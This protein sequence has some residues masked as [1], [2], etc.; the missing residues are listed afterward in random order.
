MPR[1]ATSPKRREDD[2]P[3]LLYAEFPL[4]M[5]R[6]LR[7]A[8]GTL[9]AVDAAD[10]PEGAEE[11]FDIVITSD[12]P[13]PF[14]GGLLRLVHT[15]EAVDM[16][17]AT[18]GLSFLLEH[19]GPNAPHRID[20]DLHVGVVENI[21]LARGQTRGQVRFGTSGRALQTRED[22]RGGIRLFISAGWLPLARP[23]LARAG[24]GG[25]PDLYDMPRWQLCESSSVSVPADPNARVGYSAWGFEIP[26]GDSGEK[27]A[28]GGIEMGKKVLGENGKVIDVADSD[29]RPALSEIQLRGLG[30]A[31]RGGGGG[32]GPSDAERAQ[33]A[34]EIM[35]LCVLHGLQAR[36]GEFIGQG[37]SLEQVKS[38]ILDIRSTNG[39]FSGAPAA[40]RLVPLTVKEAE[41]YSV[42]RAVQCALALRGEP[43]YKFHGLEADVHRHIEAQAK[44]ASLQG[45]NIMTRGGIFIPMRLRDTVQDDQKLAQRVGPPVTGMQLRAASSMGPSIPGGGAE[46]VANTQMEMIDLL[47]NR[48][49]C[50]ALG[51]RVLPGVVGSV[52]WPRRKA[53]PTVR[54]MGT[55]P[56]A[57][58]T[59]SGVQFGWVISSPKTMI[60]N[61]IYPRQLVNLVNFDLEA[62]LRNVLAEGHGLAWDAGGIAGTGIDAQPLGIVANGDVQSLAMGNTVPTYKLLTQAIGMIRKK[63]FRGDGL[64][65]AAT[66]EMAAVLSAMPRVAGAGA[67]DF[68]WQG[69]IGDGT[70]AG[71]RA[72]DSTQLP[73]VGADHELIGGVWSNLVFP[74][75]GAM[76]I[77]VDQLKYSEFGQVQIVSFQ[78]GDVVNQ[79]P[80]G[81]VRCT[82][83]RLA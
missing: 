55:N 81:F 42:I 44:A 23:V 71:Y 57:G 63:N 32:N 83:A 6:Q 2:P 64:G 8:D 33:L 78:M 54:W 60:G 80:E 18:R 9:Y 77:V 62:D 15:P 20:P 82:G 58:A 35:D 22:F 38:R 46:I 68:I 53:D 7:A 51:A 45:G 26:A 72:M 36:A 56:G 27:P 34:G 21:K 75:W 41:Q 52:T 66:P 74:L 50:T 11:V 37:L 25:K 43:G 67:T 49:V 16:S 48:S 73:I 29:P 61:V 17:L 4:E 69:P 76:E 30:G 31:P 10:A 24:T 13:I 1:K 5:V 3:A 47:R 12:A 19:G 59:P 39:D 65:W 28:Q 14:P 40:E 79:R 70:V